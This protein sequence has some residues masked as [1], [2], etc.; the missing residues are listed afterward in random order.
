[1]TLS[2]GSRMSSVG[3][4][5]I[6]CA[7]RKAVFFASS[8]SI[9]SQTNCPAYRSRDLSV[10]TKALIERQVCHH[11]A[12]ASTKTGRSADF[13]R[14]IALVESFS[15]HGRTS[16]AWDADATSRSDESRSRFM[17]GKC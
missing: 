15:I 10:K 6:G 9:E 11:G 2:F 17:A 1:M 16:C 12:H 3:Q 4:T 8:V 7:L 13:A 14:A 5:L